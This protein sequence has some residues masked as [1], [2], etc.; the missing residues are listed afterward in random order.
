[1]VVEREGEGLLGRDGLVGAGRGGRL[2]GGK[3][4]SGFRT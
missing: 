2:L 1:M 3:K 4:I